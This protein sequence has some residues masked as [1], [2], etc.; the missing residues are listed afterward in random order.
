MPDV[1]RSS[2]K[3]FVDTNSLLRPLL[4]GLAIYNDPTDGVSLVARTLLSDENLEKIAREADLDIRAT[5]DA[6]M[7]GIVNRLRRG[8]KISSTRER[9]IYT[10]GY[11]ARDP[12]MA[13]K[14][15]Q[16]TLDEFVEASLGSN[17][18]SSDSA[19]EF[20]SQQ[21]EEYEN[22][23]IESEMR[24]ADFTRSRMDRAP[25]SSGS[26][27]T[28][29]ERRT[30]ELQRSELKLLELESQLSATNA[31]LRG[32][33]PIFGL[34]TAGTENNQRSIRTKF[35]VRIRNLE[36]KLDEL[37]I[38]YTK[39]HP[40]AKRTQGL[41]DGLNAQR[42]RSIQNMSTVSKETGS[43][44]QFG[45]VNQNPVYQEL[46]LTAAQ[47]TNQI[48]SLKVRVEATKKKI[49]EL[50]KMVDLVPQIEAEERSLNRDYSM[51]NKKYQDL[52]SR[53]DQAELSRK[54]D[55][56]TDDV[57]FRILQPPTR[58]GKPSGPKRGIFYTA[59]LLL[60]FGSG[61]A[62]AFLISQI[63]PVV[64]SVN[65]LKQSFGIPV[66]GVVTDTNIMAIQKVN[67]RRMVVFTIS[68]LSV[69]V[70][71]LILIWTEIAYGK[72][73]LHLLENI[74]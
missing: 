58:S 43:Y 39:N 66:L 53:K 26:Y 2:A 42:D 48:A 65:Q 25:G 16:I 41:L 64:F 12:N 27:Y 57:Q 55:A 19:E 67:K 1:Y 24:R 72:V 38:K 28:R 68:S 74:I 4:R 13:Q 61:A 46:K 23:L 22:R 35:D 20:L 3:V 60:G 49:V 36:G 9:N 52:L 50:D 51:I 15:V 37:L 7:K 69:L 10:I 32:E 56:S 54:A 29:L 33:S 70:I 14:I 8:I 5:T 18:K 63:K 59:I 47:Y 73:P 17:R 45:N 21:I 40:D 6:Q 30:Q 11:T 34:T 62:V 31:Q 44:V 71:Y